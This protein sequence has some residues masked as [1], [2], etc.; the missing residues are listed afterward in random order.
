MLGHAIT[1]RSI[2]AWIPTLSAVTSTYLT[3][4][5]PVTFEKSFLCGALAK[6]LN[7]LPSLTAFAHKSLPELQQLGATPSI[8]GTMAA[9]LCAR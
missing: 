5:I 7:L 8:P 3:T 9:S 6:G 4:P 2:F 1:E